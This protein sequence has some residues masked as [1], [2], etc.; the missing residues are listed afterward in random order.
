MQ[1]FQTTRFYH[2][3]EGVVVYVRDTLI[4]RR[5]PDLEIRGLEEDWVEKTK[6]KKILIG[7]HIIVLMECL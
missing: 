5:R 6:S 3:V 2:P 4:C 7:G 1:P